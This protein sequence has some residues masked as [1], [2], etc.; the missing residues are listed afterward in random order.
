MEVS[1][2]TDNVGSASFNKRLS[3]QRALAVKNYLVSKGVEQDRIVAV[4]Y[5]FEKPVA[6]NDTPEGRQQNRRVEMK[7]LNQN[8]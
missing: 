3:K 5:G 7:I 1:G 2:H 6:S 8:Q 4:G